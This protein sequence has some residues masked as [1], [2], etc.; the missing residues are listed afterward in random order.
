MK[1]TVKEVAYVAS[2]A[3][4]EMAEGEME[5]FAGQLSAILEFADKLNRLET[6]DIL[7]TAHVLPLKNVFREDRVS[8]GLERKEAL[9]NAPE[10]E[11]GMFRVPRV[12]E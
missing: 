5:K 10:V 11:E 3:R 12:I 9:L 7:P 8:P 1:L 2:L 6:E 4:L